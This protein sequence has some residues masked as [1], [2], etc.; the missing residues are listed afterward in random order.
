MAVA[1][2]S[3]PGDA[4]GAIEIELSREEVQHL[5]LGVQVTVR[6]G[7]GADSRVESVTLRITQ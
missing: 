1:T 5:L 3:E 4:P 2:I 6:P 7:A